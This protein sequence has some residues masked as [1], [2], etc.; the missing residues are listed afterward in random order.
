M[1]SFVLVIGFIC[2]VCFFSSCEKQVDLDIPNQTP[3]MVINSIL[4]PGENLLL[5]LRRSFTIADRNNDSLW[6]NQQIENSY[7]KLYKND[8]FVGDLSVDPTNKL[9]YKLNYSKFEAGDKYTLIGK[10]IGFPSIFAETVIPGKPE[11]YITNFV[12]NSV[13]Q[14]F[15]KFSLEV[16]IVDNIS[17][18]NYYIV[19][20]SSK[21]N[22][23]LF[24]I[25]NGE[26]NQVADPSIIEL[27]NDYYLSDKL[28]NGNTKVISIQSNFI[29]Q[30]S[31]PNQTDT[32]W[33]DCKAITKDFYD[34]MIST[35]KQNAN[36]FDIFA[37]P[38]LIKHNIMGG[39][40]VFGACNSVRTPMVI[41]S[42]KLGQ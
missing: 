24:Y 18:E 42:K 32:F 26:N 25:Y 15:Y 29:T 39:Y 28:F 22:N 10:A 16:N 3:K 11:V 1:K 34:Y 12:Y 30:I 19:S 7:F 36:D 31:V 6:Y 2:V 17:D 8:Q 9:L 13:E 37:E 4:A 21:N 35:Y 14:H 20:L 23:S 41:Y 5:N 38:T 40:G 33:V 27:N